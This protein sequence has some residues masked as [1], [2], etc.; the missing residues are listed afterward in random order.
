MIT[1]YDFRIIKHVYG[2]GSFKIGLINLIKV[3]ILM[4]D[5]SKTTD[6]NALIKYL[7]SKA[8]NSQ[9]YMPVRFKKVGQELSP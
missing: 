9:G 1:D 7:E 6:I 5:I 2:K 8:S 3:G 4:F